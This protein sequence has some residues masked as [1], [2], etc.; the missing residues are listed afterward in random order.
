MVLSCW[1]MQD[2]RKVRAWQ[3]AQAF[4]VA[5]HRLLKTFPKKGYSRLKSQMQNSAETIADTIAEGCGTV[6]QPD[7][8]RFL[9]MSLRETSE[10]EGQLDR[11]FRY[12]LMKRPRW[13]AYTEEI[14][15][16]RK[17]T[18]GLR[19]S[20]VR[21]YEGDPDSTCHLQRKTQNGAGELAPD[22]G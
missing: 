22:A 1:R 16:I 8:A 7:F 2:F 3:R 12:G 19:N 10:L 14:Q 21:T 11:A 6:T 18:L 17:M 15:T 20:V 9:A 13:I 5:I 4:T